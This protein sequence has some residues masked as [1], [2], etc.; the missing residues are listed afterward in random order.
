MDDMMFTS[1]KDIFKNSNVKIET[2]NDEYKV[3]STALLCEAASMDG[4]FDENEKKLILILIQKQFNVDENEAKKIYIEGKNLAENS[5]QLYG[6]TRVIKESWDNEKR[7]SL[8]E[9][10]WELAYVDGELDAAEDML[11]RRIAGLIHVEDRDRIEAKQR[12][13]KKLNK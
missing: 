9:M 13:L 12:I 8:L 7:I 11:I 5:S 6:F 4:V 3:A 1:F 2:S 10:L